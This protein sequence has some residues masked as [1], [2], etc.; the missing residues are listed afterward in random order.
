LE[1]ASTSTKSRRERQHGHQRAPATAT[2]ATSAD[3]TTRYVRIG[4]DVRA[5][6]ELL[7]D[8]GELESF[9]KALKPGRSPKTARDLRN[10][11]AA[12]LEWLLADPQRATITAIARALGCHRETVSRLIGRVGTCPQRGRGGTVSPT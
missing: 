11:L 12:R 1:F 5:I 8:E 10:R 6:R 9:R 7:D 4:N 3:G 2:K